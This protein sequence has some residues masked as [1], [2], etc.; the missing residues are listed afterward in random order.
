MKVFASDHKAVRA[1][2]SDGVGKQGSNRRS[3]W[4]WS[5]DIGTGSKPEQ[6]IKT[7]PVVKE[8]RAGPW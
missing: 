3:W 6:W 1:A 7:D 5:R 2:V 8:G 4:D